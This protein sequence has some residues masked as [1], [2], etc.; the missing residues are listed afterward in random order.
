VAVDSVRQLSAPVNCG[1]QS[2]LTK[3]GVGQTRAGPEVATYIAP[4]RGAVRSAWCLPAEGPPLL[5]VLA[6]SVSKI[7]GSARSRCSA[8]WNSVRRPER[9]IRPRRYEGSSR[10]AAGLVDSVP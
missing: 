10:R 2:L 5:P 7:L 4:G 9:V 6:G 1:H 8:Q 3:F